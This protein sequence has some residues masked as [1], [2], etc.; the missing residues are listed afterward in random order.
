MQALNSAG[1]TRKAL[2]VTGIGMFIAFLFLVPLTAFAA[3]TLTVTTDKTTYAVGATIK[4]SG[5]VTPAPG[6]SG[7]N[8]AVS[9]VTPSG[10]TADA[11]Q[12]TVNSA[13]GAYNGTFVTGGPTYTPQGMYTIKAVYNGATASGTFQYGNATTSTS[14]SASGGVT[15]TII[16]TIIESSV[17][18]ISQG[19]VT[20]TI[21]NNLPGTTVTSVVTSVT[22]TQIN[23][24]TSAPDST[25]I[26][27]GAVG[28]IVAI[29]AIILVVLLMR[30]K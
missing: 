6:L 28:L 29:V 30:K 25:G 23:S 5:T 12:F 11:N 21:V 9:I 14:S 27:I 3:S 16:T 26:A 17:T 10:S 20:T 13:T 2:A 22:T 15:T 4:V 24:T 18:T 8:V 7:T 1:Y 19:G